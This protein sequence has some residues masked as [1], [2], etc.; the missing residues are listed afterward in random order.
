[1][2]NLST[3]K[4]T[5][6]KFAEYYDL[7]VGNYSDDL[8]LYKSFCTTENNIL[9]I[10][11]GT[12]RI[13]KPLLDSGLKVTGV[14]ISDEMLELAK[15]KLVPYIESHNLLLLNHDFS[16]EKLNSR[17]DRAFITFYTFNY[18]IN[19]PVSFL[20][21]VYQS[22]NNNSVLVMDLFFPQSLANK[23]D[24]NKWAEHEFC[25]NNRKVHLK[26][27]RWMENQVEH[28]IQIYKE[29][30]K[31]ITIETERKYYKPSEI[32]QILQEAGFSN[33]QFSLSFD[34]EKFTD[35]IRETDLVNNYI[36]KSI[37]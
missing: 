17:F 26:G 9:E 29:N 32:K 28:R 14:D 25:F 24:E 11:C 30:G 8:N 12:G 31:E 23:A 35:E 5:Y 4:E 3:S 22:L 2:S 7:Y 18:I 10:G 1:M 20:K 33:V 13:L 37:C 15:H 34:D 27:K 21:N 36:V 16:K 19:N 6:R